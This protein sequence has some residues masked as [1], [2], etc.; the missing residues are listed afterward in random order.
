MTGLLEALASASNRVGPLVLL[1]AVAAVT[2]YALL[3]LHAI[4]RHRTILVLR[5]V[6]GGTAGVAVA[7]IVL[8]FLVIA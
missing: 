2:A 3:R 6:A 5:A 1:L 4:E 7:L 8:R